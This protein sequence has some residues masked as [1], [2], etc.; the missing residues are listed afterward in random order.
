MESKGGR[1]GTR[2][3]EFRFVSSFFPLVCRHGGTVRSIPNKAVGETLP[4]VVAREEWIKEFSR[5]N[6]ELKNHSSSGTSRTNFLASVGFVELPLSRAGI[7]R[8]S[9][10]CVNFGN[11][12]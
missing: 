1:F 6:K 12:T 9:G 11:S 3:P 8:L 5:R 10:N 2:F 4:F 7:R